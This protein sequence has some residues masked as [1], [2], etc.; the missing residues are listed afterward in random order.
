MKSLVLRVRGNRFEREKAFDPW[1]PVTAVPTVIVSR[2]DTECSL[3][4]QFRTCTRT[5]VLD[6][7]HVKIMLRVFRYNFFFFSNSRTNIHSVVVRLTVRCYLAVTTV[8]RDVAFA[9]RLRD[10]ST[11]RSGVSPISISG[12]FARATDRKMTSLLSQYPTSFLVF[13]ASYKC[14][15]IRLFDIVNV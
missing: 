8:M 12:S 4:Y 15:P 13:D 11:A 3:K 10:K 9:H 6:K 14:L 5:C 1:E 7:I 2:A